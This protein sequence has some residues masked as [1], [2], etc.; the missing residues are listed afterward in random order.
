MKI[1]TWYTP[2]GEWL[3][4][5]CGHCG[6]EDTRLKGLIGLGMEEKKVL[7]KLQIIGHNEVS[8][9]HYLIK[10]SLVAYG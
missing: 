5:I 10:Y 3:K 4:Y 1:A 7:G 2:E 9:C 6:V 8:T